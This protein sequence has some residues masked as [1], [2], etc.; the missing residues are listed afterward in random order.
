MKLIKIISLLALAVFI[1]GCSMLSDSEAGVFE[2]GQNISKVQVNIGGNG[3]TILP[4]LFEGFC[5]FVLSA[6]PT[7]NNSNP[8]PASVEIICDEYGY[9]DNYG[10][11]NL[12]YGAWNIKVAAYV[13][14]EISD[15]NYQEFIAARG[16][17]PFIANA[18][19]HNIVVPVIT[20]EPGGTGKFD[21]NVTYPSAGS[22]IVKLDTWPIGGTPVFTNS[23]VMSGNPAYSVDVPSGVYFL[24]VTGNNS[25]NGKT[26]TRSEIVHIYTNSVTYVHYDLIYDLSVLITIS[27]NASVIKNDMPAEEIEVV[28]YRSDNDSWLGA[29]NV[30]INDGGYWEI[31][32][33]IFDEQTEVYFKISYY[34]SSW[35]YY[36]GIETGVTAQIFDGDVSIPAINLEFSTIY[37]GGYADIMVNGAYPD[38]AEIE[39]FQVGNDSEHLAMSWVEKLNCSW[40][41]EIPKFAAETEVYFIVYGDDADG[42]SFAKRFDSSIDG[43]V[44]VSDFDYWYI[45]LVDDNILIRGNVTVTVGGSNEYLDY[46]DHIF[47]FGSTQNGWDFGGTLFD[48]NSGEWAMLIP[49][50][51]LNEDLYISLFVGAEGCHYYEDRSR[52]INLTSSYI[53]NINFM[54]D[55]TRE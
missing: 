6:E 12:P 27:G 19:Y 2:N 3:R 1:A 30:D 9:I 16:S 15:D 37:L 43:T 44:K 45:I 49:G 35:K 53:P 40:E 14:V 24:T 5:K 22:V 33:P 41:L 48:V 10:V 42:V 51:H 23:S 34:D 7:G 52:K 36:Y 50:S 38:W 32:L 47:D 4:I 13:K 20:P 18:M 31:V 17:I 55:L 21:Y 54:V 25:A 8:A 39:V 28:M 46:W 11:I 29:A 26:V